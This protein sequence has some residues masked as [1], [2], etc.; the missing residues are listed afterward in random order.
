M[1]EK[2][3]KKKIKEY[4]VHFFRVRR[5]KVEESP[6]FLVHISLSFRIPKY[7]LSLWEVQKKLWKSLEDSERWQKEQG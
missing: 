5:R 3:E 6:V 1:G 7:Y 4:K 2:Y